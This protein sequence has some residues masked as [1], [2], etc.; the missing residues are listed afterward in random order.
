VNHQQLDRILDQVDVV[1][2]Y[3]VRVSQIVALIL[4]IYILTF[5]KGCISPQLPDHPS[6]QQ[7]GQKL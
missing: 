6:M 4:I 3:L 1:L 5:V 7:K 2:S